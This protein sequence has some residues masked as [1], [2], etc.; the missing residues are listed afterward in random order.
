MNPTH[1][2]HPLPVRHPRAAP[3][4]PRR[5][6]DASRARDLLVELRGIAASAFRENLSLRQKLETIP[7]D[8]VIA[9]AAQDIAEIAG[10]LI[11][12]AAELE[13]LT[14]RSRSERGPP[15]ALLSY[16]D[17][18]T[19]TDPAPSCDPVAV[20]IVN[21][22]AAPSVRHSPS[23]TVHR[24]P[25]PRIPSPASASDNHDR[26]RDDDHGDD[27]E[28]NSSFQLITVGDTSELAD[29][30]AGDND[31][32]PTAAADSVPREPT[33][34]PAAAISDQARIA[35]LESL[36]TGLAQLIWRATRSAH[37]NPTADTPAPPLAPRD[38]TVDAIPRFLAAAEDRLAPLVDAALARDLLTGSPGPLLIDLAS[39]A[40][41]RDLLEPPLDADDVM[42]F[43]QPDDLE[44]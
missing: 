35:H 15:T 33:P 31:T 25:S 20:P 39:P 18:S 12:M 26:D 38:D 22:A 14:P 13:P 41:L 3:V 44:I 19:D 37:V 5:T 7:R 34:T 23:P 28:S 43:L 6:Q 10:S 2:P 32:L 29:P 36:C 42:R 9:V 1:S 16:K 30:A 8:P 21:E 11:A 27:A 4:K 40:G 24:S 17:Q